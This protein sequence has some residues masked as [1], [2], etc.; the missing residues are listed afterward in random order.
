[1]FG[2]ISA[3]LQYVVRM[4]PPFISQNKAVWQG[5]NPILKGT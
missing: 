4:G 1:M 3:S 2:D 5:S